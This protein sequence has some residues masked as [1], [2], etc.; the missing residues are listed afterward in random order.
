MKVTTFKRCRCRGDDGRELGARCPHLRRGDGCANPRHGGG[1]WTIEVPA[2]TTIE[3]RKRVKGGA[4]RTEGDAER[5]GKRIV[6]LLSIPAPGETGARERAEVLAVVRQ[7]LKR[8]EPLPDAE[9][10]R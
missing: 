6:E 4:H 7:A 1:Q 9:D 5:E 3:H 8:R 2:D 10:I